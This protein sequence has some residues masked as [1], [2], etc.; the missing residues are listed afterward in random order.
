P[1]IT[2]NLDGQV[3]TKIPVNYAISESGKQKV[4]IKVLPVIGETTLSSGAELK[5]SIQLF[6]V[7]DGFEFKQELGN[8]K[9]PKISAQEK[10]PFI[11]NHLFFDAEI[12]YKMRV[13]W[14]DGV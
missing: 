8:Y 13:F 3:S 12:P 2:L 4:T 5:C 14:K 11:T 10:I 7:Y 1:V 6:D 9:T